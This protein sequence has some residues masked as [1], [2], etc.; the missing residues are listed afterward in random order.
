MIPEQPT[1][2]FVRTSDDAL[3]YLDWKGPGRPVHLLHANGFCAGTYSP[4]I[5]HLQKDLHIVASDI[6]GHGDSQQPVFKRIQSWEIFADDLKRVIEHTLPKPAIGIGHS[7]GAVAT[8]IAAVKYPE[9]FAGIILIDPVIPP[10]HRLW[11]MA[12][13]RWLSLSSR[14]PLAKGA[15]RRRRLF[16]DKGRA[17]DHFAQGRG[18]FKTWSEE[19]ISAY[20][21]CGLLEKDENRA[22]LKC[23]PELEAQIFESVPLSIWKYCTNLKCPVLALRGIHSDTFSGAVAVRLK[24]HMADYELVTIENA[25]HFIPM[26]QPESCAKAILDFIHRRL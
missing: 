17:L 26:E 8:L 18:I 5:Q 19:F 25:G 10:R 2:G 3:H 9:L 24:S 15:R 4:F 1:E 6:R 7:L 21:E 22:V 13:L 20:L 14:L 23:D 12:L 16:Q 11:G